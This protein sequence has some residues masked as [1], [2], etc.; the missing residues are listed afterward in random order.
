MADISRIILGYKLLLQT[1]MLGLVFALRPKFLALALKL[2]SLAM[3]LQPVALLTS[4]S[5]IQLWSLKWIHCELSRLVTIGTRIGI[6]AQS[7][8]GEQDI[9]ARKYM[10]EKLTKCQ[11]FT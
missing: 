5:D 10:H 11:N 7:T 6:G 3:A 8:L 2:K 4:L 9:F 1:I